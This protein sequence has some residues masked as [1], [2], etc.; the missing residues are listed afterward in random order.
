MAHDEQLV[1]GRYVRDRLSLVTN[2]EKL[3][4]YLDTID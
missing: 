3:G 1:G 2:D 4:V